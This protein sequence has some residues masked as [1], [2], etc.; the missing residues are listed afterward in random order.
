MV[1]HLLTSFTCMVGLHATLL[2]EVL[3]ANGTPHSILTAMNGRFMREF[4][5]VVI[6]LVYVKK[7]LLYLN[8]SSTWANCHVWVIFYIIFEGDFF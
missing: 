8:R 7:A 2:A 5:A 3:F 1:L 4:L 6:F